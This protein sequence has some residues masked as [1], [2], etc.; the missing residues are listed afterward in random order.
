VFGFFRRS[1]TIK[2]LKQVLIPDKS[3]TQHFFW[4]DIKKDAL[5]LLLMVRP[6][7]IEPATF[8]LKGSCSTS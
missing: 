2:N 6:A 1:E 3:A 5:A 7:G 8:S 4:A